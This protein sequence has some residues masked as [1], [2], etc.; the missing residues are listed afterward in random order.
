MDL[1]KETKK[2]VKWTSSASLLT[3]ILQLLLTAL[4]ARYL[5]SEA[6]GLMAIALF[7]INFSQ[8]FIDMGISNAII[9]RQDI[10]KN[11]L[12]TLYWLNIFIGVV[13]F[14][15]VFFLS[16]FIANFY[17]S[18]ELSNVIR[19]ISITFLIQPLGA[20]F[21]ILL[22]KELWFKDL[23]L[24]TIFSQISSFAVGVFLAINGFGVYALVFS[25]L[26]LTLISTFLLIWAGLR[27]HKPSFYFR[28]SDVREFISFGLFQ[29]G[30]KIINYINHE[31]DSLIVGKIL[32]IEILG[33]YNI[34]KSF[35]VKPF[36][37]INPILTRIGFPLM[38]KIQNDNARVG[39]VYL[40]MVTV[41]S[42]VNFPIFIFMYT[43]P[44][45]VVHLMFGKEWDAAITPLKI[46]SVYSLLRSTLNPIG[47]LQLA[48][49]RADLGFFWNL[50]QLFILPISI[51]IGSY[52]GIIGVCIALTISQLLSFSVI[53]KLMI[54]KLCSI[55][56]KKYYSSFV[57]PLLISI[58]TVL[59]LYLGHDYFKNFKDI[60]FNIIL[61]II[62]TIIYC[63]INYF[64][65]SRLKKMLKEFK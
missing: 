35:V 60:I 40:T 6:F 49:G 10:T 19:W 33:V 3:A 27:F 4:L 2:A 61:I 58:F 50:F 11:Q 44:E 23:A 47:T 57:L 65:N 18:H 37:V 20:Q 8:F 46:L 25:N 39:K 29:M 17:N 12:D 28:F 21:G 55:N 51:F 45:V 36:Q 43:F 16:P 32:G 63:S 54:V 64:F 31:I 52:W 15:L 48:K 24:R 7:I 1:K 53:G 26:I 38:A 30:E 62:Y 41:L 42:Y 34:A 5:N 14:L 56:L 13:I 59:F 22:R 9:H